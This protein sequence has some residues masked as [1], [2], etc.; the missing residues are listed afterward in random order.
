[1]KLG[2]YARNGLEILKYYT[3]NY[4]NELKLRLLIVW[5][6]FNTVVGKEGQTVL[7]GFQA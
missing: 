3:G 2:W 6:I 5:Q 1:M 7:L 4:E